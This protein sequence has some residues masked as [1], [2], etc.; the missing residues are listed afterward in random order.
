MIRMY[1]VIVCLACVPVGEGNDKPATLWDLKL[2]I[3]L[4]VAG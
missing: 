4:E 3:T 2:G 1:K